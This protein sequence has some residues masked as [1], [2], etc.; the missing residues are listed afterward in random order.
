[1][2]IFNFTWE[3]ITKGEIV[4]MLIEYL[5]IGDFFKL[6]N[7]SESEIIAILKMHGTH[8]NYELDYCVC[9]NRK[10]IDDGSFIS[11]NYN[12]MGVLVCGFNEM[13][14]LGTKYLD[15]VEW[16]KNGWGKT[17]VEVHDLMAQKY[18]EHQRYHN[19]WHIHTTTTYTTTG[20]TYA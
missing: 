5:E 14:N 18:E 16:V 11:F 6:F 1:M 12:N 20:T 8:R 3:D 10:R 19:Y 13:N 9:F 17:C 7:I 2:D 15:H 4:S